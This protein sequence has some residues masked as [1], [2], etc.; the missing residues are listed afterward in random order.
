MSL[1]TNFMSQFRIGVYSFFVVKLVN[2]YESN[3]Y[4]DAFLMAV[5]RKWQEVFSNDRF[6]F[7]DGSTETCSL[8]DLVNVL[9]SKIEITENY[10]QKLEKWLF[11]KKVN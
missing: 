9:D 11:D 4:K 7:N 6:G 10:L 8:R 1:F 3:K 2:I 5:I